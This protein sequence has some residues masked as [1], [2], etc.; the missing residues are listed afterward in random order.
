MSMSPINFQDRARDINAQRDTITRQ[1]LVNVTQ[2]DEL[3][4]QSTHYNVLN[5]DIAIL[6]NKTNDLNRQVTQQEVAKQSLSVR[7]TK[8]RVVIAVVSLLALGL[9]A[10][11]V[12]GFAGGH[13][14]LSKPF[15]Y[16]LT[17]ASVVPIILTV[18]CAYRLKKTTQDVQ[19]LEHSIREIIVQS[20]HNLET[21][22]NNRT[23][24][25]R[26]YTSLNQLQDEIRGRQNEL[27]NLYALLQQDVQN[28]Y[29]CCLREIGQLG[30]Q[31]HEYMQIEECGNVLKEKLEEK[32]VVI[33]RIR[34]ETDNAVDVDS[35]IARY[36]RAVAAI[37]D[38]HQAISDKEVK[39]LKEFRVYITAQRTLEQSILDAERQVQQ[40]GLQYTQIQPVCDMAA[41]KEKIE[42][43]QSNIESAKKFQRLLKRD[44]TNSEQIKRIQVMVAQLNAHKDVSSQ[45][46]PVQN[47][48]EEMTREI[49]GRVDSSDKEQTSRYFQKINQASEM[50]RS[51]KNKQAE[52]E[53]RKLQKE[54]KP[55]SPAGSA[56][57]GDT[58]MIQMDS[59][60][61]ENETRFNNS[62]LAMFSLF[63]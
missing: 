24:R 10:F 55:K 40:M 18:Y 25:M 15:L 52:K 14:L 31:L 33:T 1:D 30:Q 26:L 35:Q 4:R 5:R 7:Q 41:L 60:S 51:G 9:L 11:G 63:E 45:G 62:T 56:A 8:Q 2:S 48:I 20:N 38:V 37:A 57:D 6:V 47:M 19:Q 44:E 28:E 12:T 58:S 43:L 13:S 21:V 36:A 49:V 22:T 54:L 61:V 23:E 34:D 3:A 27:N 17:C 46:C 32:L 42:V 59:F 29:V 16:G 39:K 53:L 50:L